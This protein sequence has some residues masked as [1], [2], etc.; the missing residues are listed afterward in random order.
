MTTTINQ[1]CMIFST[2]T[3]KLRYSFKLCFVS[4]LLGGKFL[5]I[6]PLE[7]YLGSKFVMNI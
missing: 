5:K 4:E 3:H 7:S 1:K 6:Q 2:D